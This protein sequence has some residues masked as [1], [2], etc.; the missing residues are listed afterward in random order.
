M[1]TSNE[2]LGDT[3]MVVDWIGEQEGLGEI[4]MSDSFFSTTT[5]VGNSKIR[6]EKQQVNILKYF[7]DGQLKFFPFR[8]YLFE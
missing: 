5:A 7:V 1:A 8:K 6:E 4:L 3:N 2:V